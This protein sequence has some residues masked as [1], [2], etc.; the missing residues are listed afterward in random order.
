MRFFKTNILYRWLYPNLIW[1]KPNKAKKIYLTFDD[2]PIPDVTTWVLDILKEEQIKATFFCIG[3]NVTK[4]PEI[5]KQIQKDGHAIGN[6]TFNHLK[7]WETKTETYLSNVAKCQLEFEKQTVVKN[8]LFRPPY[9]KIKR[10]QINALHKKGYKIIM[11]EILTYDFDSSCKSELCLNKTLK[12]TK[13]GSIIVFHDSVK[14]SKNL[15]AI[16]QQTIQELK[17]RGFVFEVIS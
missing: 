14:A 17:K 8:K 15:K 9:G 12:N 16:L 4:N 7:G 13:S 2:G 6:H 10:S 1:H 3:D 5:F 11:W